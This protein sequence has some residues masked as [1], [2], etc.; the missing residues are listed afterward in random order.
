MQHPGFCSEFA[1]GDGERLLFVPSSACA[2]ALLGGRHTNRRLPF[3]RPFYIRDTL[4]LGTRSICLHISKNEGVG[5][6]AQGNRKEGELIN[7]G[8]R[9]R[10]GDKRRRRV[11]E[12]EESHSGAS[13]TARESGYSDAANLIIWSSLLFF[14][15]PL[16]T[17]TSGS[18][19]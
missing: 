10:G 18:E 13:G 5:E 7:L 11:K 1:E 14:T 17:G 9:W 6:R 2:A 12:T 15:H 8:R 19:E 3:I 16:I 4:L